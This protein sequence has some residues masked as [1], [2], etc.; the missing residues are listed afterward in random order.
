MTT[1]TLGTGVSV[2]FLD[3]SS[4]GVVYPPATQRSSTRFVFD[5]GFGVVEE[6][7][8]SGFTYGSDGV[9]SGGVITAMTGFTD[10][11]ADLWF[12]DLDLSVSAVVGFYRSGDALGLQ[13]YA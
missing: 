13:T 9:P 5:Y 8:G 7:H 12:T 3:L 2:D 10:G 11:V 6:Y 1:M 4:S